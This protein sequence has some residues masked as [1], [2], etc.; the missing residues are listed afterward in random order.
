MGELIRNFFDMLEY[1]FSIQI[2]GVFLFGNLVMFVIDRKY[3]IKF[4]FQYFFDDV[5]GNFFFGQLGC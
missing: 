1:F 2:V 4:M 3:V 5:W